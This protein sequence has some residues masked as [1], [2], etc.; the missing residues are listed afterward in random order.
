[1][2]A[3]ETASSVPGERLES[4]RIVA[5]DGAILPLRRWLPKA[6]PRAVILALHGFNDYSNAFADPGARLAR[7]GIATFAYDQRG[8][9][10]APLLGRWAGTDAM[11]SD[12]IAALALL[13]RR[14]PEV[15]LY[16]MGESMGGAVAVLAANRGA[17]ADGVIL[18]AP[19]VWGRATMNPFERT[20]LWLADLMPAF[21]W[22]PRFLPVTIRPSDNVAMLREL[23]ADPLVIKTSRSD[24]LNG[25]VDLM[26]EALDA[27]PRFTARAFILYG[28]RD[29]VVPRVPVARFIAALPPAA[30]ERQRLAL[31]RAGFHLLLRDL[32]GPQVTADVLAWINDAAAPL[33]S[34]ADRDARALLSGRQAAPESAA[35]A[36]A[37]RAPQP[38]GSS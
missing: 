7:H 26:G 34:G 28:L 27:A 23:G 14:Y 8:F 4:D 35:Q 1:M 19:A 36:G 30:A 10:A 25:L 16:L 9:G 6:D 12:A 15:P 2:A 37:S 17:P 13:R 11:V 29:E 21:V 32:D 18:L 20:G 5:R 3:A 24:T 38:R 22:S 33:P 31:Y